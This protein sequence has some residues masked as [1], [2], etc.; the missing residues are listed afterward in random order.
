MLAAAA[1]SVSTGNHSFPRQ[2]TVNKK[3][4]QSI[5]SQS[6]P[7]S[8]VVDQADMSTPDYSS[9]N[10]VERRTGNSSQ[11]LIPITCAY[12]QSLCSPNRTFDDTPTLA[13]A[14]SSLD[15]DAYAISYAP[16]YLDPDVY[17]ISNP[18]SSL[19]LAN[20]SSSLD[21]DA[22]AINYAPSCLDPDVYA[23]SN[24]SS[25]LAYVN[26][27]IEGV[28]VSTPQD[29]N[30]INRTIGRPLYYTD[31]TGRETLMQEGLSNNVNLTNTMGCGDES[32]GMLLEESTSSAEMPNT[33]PPDIC[34][35]VLQ[36]Q[37]SH[38]VPQLAGL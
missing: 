2:D 30:P 11:Y 24:P 7:S 12:S 21:P 35:A 37:V 14:S 23:I 28:M 33:P 32:H 9:P 3:E 4:G 22:Y 6:S 38:S 17:A 26:T 29:S 34:S 13:N 25:S 16:S 31:S 36:S 5:S 8:T 10:P 20:A 19:S 1:T 27:P 18:S 15:P